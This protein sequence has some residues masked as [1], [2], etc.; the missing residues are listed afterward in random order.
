MSVQTWRLLV[1][2]PTEGATNMVIDEAIWRGRQASTTP[3]TVRFFAWEPPT[4]SLGY[5]QSLGRDV[6]VE[7]CGHLYTEAE[8]ETARATVDRMVRGGIPLVG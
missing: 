8:Y 2:E 4:V 6:D 5:G 3:P 1:T 7:A